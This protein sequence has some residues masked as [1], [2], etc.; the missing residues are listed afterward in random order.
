MVERLNYNVAILWLALWLA[1]ILSNSRWNCYGYDAVD[2]NLHGHFTKYY[3]YYIYVVT[4]KLLEIF[5]NW[6]NIEMDRF[7]S[8]RSFI[9]FVA[10]NHSSEL[11]AVYALQKSWNGRRVCSRGRKKSQVVDYSRFRGEW[12]LSNYPLVPFDFTSHRSPRRKLEGSVNR[13]SY[14]GRSGSSHGGYL[15]LRYQKCLWFA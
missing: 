1:A 4:V 9:V 7:L 14:R 11:S 5:S 13:K 10:S 3:F 15:F 8:L 2:S 12:I 6:R